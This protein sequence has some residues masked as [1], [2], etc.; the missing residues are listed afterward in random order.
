[1]EGTSQ[2]FGSHG[3]NHAAIEYLAEDVGGLEQDSPVN[4]KEYNKLC[5]ATVEAQC[6]CK[7][8]CIEAQ[9]NESFKSHGADPDNTTI[10]H[11]S[12]NSSAPLSQS[13]KANIVNTAKAPVNATV[14]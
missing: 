9:L 7:K 5:A 12:S 4:L 1:M 13:D 10:K 8:E 2:H 3:K 11:R 14:G 6:G